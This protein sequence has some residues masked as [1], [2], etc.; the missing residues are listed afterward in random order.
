[1]FPPFQIVAR[2]RER[3]ARRSGHGSGQA[4]PTARTT[5][6]KS[7]TPGARR[8]HL[9]GL[10]VVWPCVRARGGCR[11]WNSTSVVGC[12]GEYEARSSSLS[13]RRDDGVGRLCANGAEK[14]T[15]GPRFSPV[16][17]RKARGARLSRAVRADEDKFR[18]LRYITLRYAT[19]YARVRY[20]DV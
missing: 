3:G 20:L 12:G 16:R 4:G 14:L 5:H 2:E 6:G 19:L 18:A 7:P 1:M 17:A 15:H 11:V 9:V 8:S 13:V 10:S